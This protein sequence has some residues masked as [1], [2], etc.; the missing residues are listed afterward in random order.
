MSLS[1]ESFDSSAIARA[2]YD[3][4]EQ[5]LFVFFKRESATPRVWAYT[6]VPQSCF[7]GLARAGSQGRYFQEHIRG[8]F[9]YRQLF[10]ADV[11]LLLKRL[12]ESACSVQISWVEQLVGAPVAQDS[13]GLF[14]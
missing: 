5:V 6:A 1:D 10:A 13:L 8:Q 9:A 4:V 7:D 12:A 3:P 2:S 11:E 14:F